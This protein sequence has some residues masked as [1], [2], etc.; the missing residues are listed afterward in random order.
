[1]APS[2][3][4]DRGVALGL[5]DGAPPGASLAP[6]QGGAPTCIDGVLCPPRRGAR[7]CGGDVGGERRTGKRKASR[8][9]T[10]RTRPATCCHGG[11][12][13][14]KA[15]DPEVMLEAG[16]EAFTEGEWRGHEGA[17]GF[18]ANQMDALEGMWLRAD[19]YIDVDEDCLVVTL[20]FGGRARHTGLD[21]R[22]SPAHIF[23]LRNGRVLQWQ[24]FADRSE[25]FEA[26][27]L[28]E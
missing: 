13:V 17:V 5:R 8:P 11:D 28:S 23:R 15:F 21:V 4:L 16:G 10:R 1:M 20:T 27:G 3:M 24:V 9:S 25:A 14:E 7:Y 26:A 18:V 2:N 22:M 19:E 12:T 6:C